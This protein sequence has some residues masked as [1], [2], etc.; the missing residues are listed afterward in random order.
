MRLTTQDVQAIE[1]TAR[2][3]FAP[4]S[5]VR[6]FGPRLDDQRRGGNIDL[7]RHLMT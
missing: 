6:L 3:F 4:G 5:V 7:L 1:E 2:E